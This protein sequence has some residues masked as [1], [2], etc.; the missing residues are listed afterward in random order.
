M[1]D[2]ARGQVRMQGFIDFREGQNRAELV[3]FLSFW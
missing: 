2:S 1:W 3:Q